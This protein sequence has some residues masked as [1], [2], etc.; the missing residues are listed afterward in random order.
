MAHAG[1]VVAQYRLGR[2]LLAAGS[3]SNLGEARAW[4]STSAYSG[5][6]GAQYLLGRL[7]AE[8]LVPGGGLGASW[9]LTAKAVARWPKMGSV[10]SMQ[11]R[12]RLRPLARESKTLR[13]GVRTKLRYMGMGNTLGQCAV[14][15]GSTSEGRLAVMLQSLP[16][17][18]PGT[19]VTNM[20]E[21]VAFRVLAELLLD[22][23]DP[24]PQD[25][26]WFEVWPQTSCNSGHAHAVAL[27]W[28][29]RAERYRD[30]VWGHVDPSELPF[31][32]RHAL[33]VE[34]EVT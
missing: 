32:V 8:G 16:E 24:H 17:G 25:V 18:N 7:A 28:D 5:F 27:K 1:D 14:E 19:S 34:S 13:V 26:A 23:Y 31:D 33:L 3:H 9:W 10:A 20:I 29:V 6:A 4:L 22:G 21:S 2:S 12:E 15:I 30:P 11:I